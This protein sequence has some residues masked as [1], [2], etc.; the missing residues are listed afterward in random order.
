MFGENTPKSSTA[1]KTFSPILNH[2]QII[3]KLEPTISLLRLNVQI[4]VFRRHVIKVCIII[5]F[6][7][8]IV[9]YNIRADY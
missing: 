4:E 8:W 9:K 1:A 6:I 5:T 2:C 3:R 7:A